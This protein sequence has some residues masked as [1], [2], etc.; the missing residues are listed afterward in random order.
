MSLLKHDTDDIYVFCGYIS[1]C[2]NI[3][4]SRCT[5][6]LFEDT[7]ISRYYTKCNFD[8]DIGVFHSDS[9]VHIVYS[10]IVLDNVFVLCNMSTAW[11]LS[12]H[13]L[14]L[15][16]RHYAWKKVHL[17]CMQSICT[18]VLISLS[19]FQISTLLIADNGLSEYIY[20]ST[21]GYLSCLANG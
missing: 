4:L 21:G 18:V 13:D 11:K 8:I 3:I 16:R 15:F 5:K 9:W 10:A 12:S 17:L 7:C 1:I 19:R 20:L 14:Y 2:L 6:N